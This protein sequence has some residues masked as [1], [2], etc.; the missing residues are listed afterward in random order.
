MRTDVDGCGHNYFTSRFS[1]SIF[2]EGFR[3]KDKKGKRG[4]GIIMEDELSFMLTKYF[5][6]MWRFYECMRIMHCP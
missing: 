1:C 3:N 4:K 5:L 2:I 6:K